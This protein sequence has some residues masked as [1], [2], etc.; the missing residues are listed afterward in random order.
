MRTDKQPDHDEYMLP[1]GLKNQVYCE[2]F[3]NRFDDPPDDGFE[4]QHGGT[5]HG[6]QTVQQ[7]IQIQMKC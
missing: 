6:V 3:S 4:Y 5:N 2:V 7:L 1:V